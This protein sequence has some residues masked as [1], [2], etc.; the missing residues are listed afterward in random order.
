MLKS[1]TSTG[2]KSSSEKEAC[3]HDRAMLSEQKVGSFQSSSLHLQSKYLTACSQN[4]SCKL[5]IKIKFHFISSFLSVACLTFN[6]TTPGLIVYSFPPKHSLQISRKTTD[7]NKNRSQGLVH[8]HIQSVLP[9]W[10]PTDDFLVTGIVNFLFPA[11]GW[12]ETLKK[13]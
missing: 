6:Y 8:P 12:W 11:Q 7:T 13:G 10:A 5:M 1:S 4:E 9:K 3:L 2:N